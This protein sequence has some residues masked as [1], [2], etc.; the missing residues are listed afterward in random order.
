MIS[1]SLASHFRQISALFILYYF[2]MA[3]ITSSDNFVVS[4]DLDIII[5]PLS[6]LLKSISGGLP[7]SLIPNPSS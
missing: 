7:L 3:L 1:S 4:T 6:F 2:R 5:P